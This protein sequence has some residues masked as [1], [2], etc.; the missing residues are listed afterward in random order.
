MKY[1]VDFQKGFKYINDVD[2]IT[3][4]FRRT[5]SSLVDFLLLHQKKR[6]NIYIKD[7]EDFLQHDCIKIFDSIAKEHPEI[8][9]CFKL[10]RY[11]DK[12]K[13]VFL[14]IVASEVKHK[15][16]FNY[17]V[18]DWDSLWGYVSLKPSSIYITEELGFEI[19]AVAD[20][21]HSHNIEVRCFPNVAQSHWSKTPGLKKF[22]IRPEDTP[23][24]EPYV[25]VY[26]FFGSPNT[27]ETYY[28]IYAIDK[29]WFGKLNEAILS[30]NSDI[31][32]RCLLP[33]FAERRLECGKRCLRGRKCRICEAT[34]QL[35]ARLQKDDLM[36][37]TYLNKN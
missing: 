12:T 20:L 11:G 19:K 14:A 33:N 21:L 28:K 5:D 37:L 34:E 16:F 24:Y 27:V 25:D 9:F 23:W 35:S 7:E 1:C 17:F 6:I 26:E 30:F 36:L 13:D 10:K 18:H 15:Y 4:T 8:D 31:D 32:S 2:E 22:F 29:K 3:I